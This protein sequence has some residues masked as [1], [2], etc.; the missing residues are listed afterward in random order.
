MRPGD[1]RRQ[2]WAGLAANLPACTTA[3][4]GRADH[5]QGPHDMRTF[6][7]TLLVTAALVTGA[8]G[9]V[10][11][12]VDQAAERADR[13]ADTARYCVQALDVAR[14]VSDR[15]VDAAVEAGR[16]LS[17]V[18]PAEVSDDART[19]LDAAQRAQDGDPQALQTDAVVAAAERLRETT[20][21][22]CRPDE[23]Q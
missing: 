6:P 7:A 11:E 22:Q 17:E 15:D 12:A 3:H 16:E 23:G 8:C 1:E 18:A 9:Q 5:D 4:R 10:G 2:E 19:L 20:E 21:E 14:A 13:V